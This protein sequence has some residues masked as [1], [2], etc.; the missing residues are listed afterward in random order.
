MSAM[1]VISIPIGRHTK[2]RFKKRNRSTLAQTYGPSF[3]PYVYDTP[4]R[5]SWL[6]GSERA[7]VVGGYPAKTCVAQL[8]R[9]WVVTIQALA[10]DRH[11]PPT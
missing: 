9:V 8:R 6:F 11:A 1:E 7:P 2:R 3:R 5:L 10:L 4:G